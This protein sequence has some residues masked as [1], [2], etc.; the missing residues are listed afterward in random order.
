MV[1]VVGDV[2]RPSALILMNH[3]VAYIGVSGEI[4]LSGSKVWLNVDGSNVEVVT[5]G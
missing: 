5:S 3:D 4:F 1:E 2:V